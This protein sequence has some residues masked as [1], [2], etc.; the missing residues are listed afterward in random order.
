MSKPNCN[1]HTAKKNGT[2]I[3]D[4]NHLGDVVEVHIDKVKRR[5]YGIREDGIV[6][7]DSGDYGN[8]FKQPV[9]LYKI[10]YSF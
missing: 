9:M 2:I 1:F 10:Y 7:E 3:L 6:I 8:D 5:F 4:S